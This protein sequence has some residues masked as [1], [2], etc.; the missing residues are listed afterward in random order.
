[1]TLQQV[2][3]AT[4]RHYDFIKFYHYMIN[5]FPFRMHRH[6]ILYIREQ[7]YYNNGLQEVVTSIHFVKIKTN[8]LQNSLDLNPGQQ[9]LLG[10]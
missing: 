4:V 8:C 9:V 1:M 5:V 2:K 6:I 10:S 7:W 3:K